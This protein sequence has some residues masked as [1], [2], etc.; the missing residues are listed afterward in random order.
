MLGAKDLHLVRQTLT[1]TRQECTR[2]GG[3]AGN[4]DHLSATVRR[5]LGQ[6]EVLLQA[7]STSE[8]ANG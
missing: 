7:L 6:V 8:A 4:L 3:Q 5:K 2:S 1:A